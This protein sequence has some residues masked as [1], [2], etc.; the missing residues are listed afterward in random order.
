MANTCRKSQRS[1]A[2]RWWADWRQRPLPHHSNLLLRLS[3]AAP[4]LRHLSSASQSSPAAQRTSAGSAHPTPARTAP[5]PGERENKTPHQQVHHLYVVTRANKLFPSSPKVSLFSLLCVNESEVSRSPRANGIIVRFAVFLR[6]NPR[7]F[8]AMVVLALQVKELR[9][10]QRR[11][12]AER[13]ARTHTHRNP[14]I[15]VHFWGY[16]LLAAGT[17]LLLSSPLARFLLRWGCASLAGP[18]FPVSIQVWLVFRWC[19]QADFIQ[20]CQLLILNS[21]FQNQNG[22]N[23]NMT[24]DPLCNTQFLFS[25][26]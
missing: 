14:H 10:A 13:H 18:T 7:L 5:H 6:G 21:L 8:P 3:L 2:R 11:T 12:K 22:T 1:L 16:S 19:Q 4:V 24:P 23:R 15:F 25:T 26:K 20:P 17:A 9:E